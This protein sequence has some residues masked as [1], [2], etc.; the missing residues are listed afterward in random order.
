METID[1]SLK[2]RELGRT[3]FRVSGSDLPREIVGNLSSYFLRSTAPLGAQ[4]NEVHLDFRRHV[5][6]SRFGYV[7]FQSEIPLITQMLLGAAID[8]IVFRSSEA[9]LGIVLPYWSWRHVS[10]S[11]T[12]LKVGI[13]WD[14]Q[15]KSY[16]QRI[17]GRNPVTEYYGN[18]TVAGL[19][20]IAIRSDFPSNVLSDGRLIFDF[21]K[22]ITLLGEVPNEL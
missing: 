8:C 4:P 6:K 19:A 12:R 7:A 18:D 5:R 17:L 16:A 15:S 1:R 11:G 3:M 22:D 2:A 14:T 10:Q 13:N 20:F 21:S 9:Q